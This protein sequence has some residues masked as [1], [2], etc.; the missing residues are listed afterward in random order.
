LDQ[1]NRLY[2]NNGDGTF[3]D[4]APELGVDS[5]NS[6]FPAWFWDVDN[7]GDLDIWVS[8]YTA[9]IG[10]IAASYLGKP[11]PTELARLYLN[12][13]QG[14]F[15]DAAEK[16]NLRMPNAPMG[17]NFGD[18][19]NDGFLDFYLGTGYPDYH[20][21]MPNVMYWNRGGVQFDD[22]TFAGGFGSLQKGHGVA[23][24][25]LDDDGDQDVFE[26]MGGALFGDQFVDALY[27]NP[28][29]GN[30]WIGVELIGKRSNRS[31]IGARIRAT[32]DDAGQRRHIYRH[33][34]SGGSF[35]ANPLR[36]TIGLGK[37]EKVEE[38]QV[39]WPTSRTTQVF[40][41]VPVNRRYRIAEDSERPE[42][43]TAQP[44]RECAE[45]V[46]T[47]FLGDVSF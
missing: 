47:M 13:G 42:L 5:P 36:Q 33:V 10:E 38:L 8:A 3:T 32:V 35:G 23:F 11:N 25:D 4:V 15:N 34:N 6:S 29:F 37:A 2:R 27:E 43:V 46:W 31:A 40:K 39:Y 28:G 44:V 14:H 18:L 20:A 7:D 22:V 41:N 30:A 26:E 12:D 45:A 9:E 16:M 19:D 1:P 17:A 24:V 21:L